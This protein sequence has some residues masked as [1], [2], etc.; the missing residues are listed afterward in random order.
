M[1]MRSIRWRLAA[2]YVLLTLLIV[3]LVGT[4][5]LWLVRA[6]ME[7][8]EIAFLTANANSVARQVLPLWQA[9]SVNG[10]VTYP[11]LLQLAPGMFILPEVPQ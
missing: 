10:D 6:S 5:T 7:R 8:Q 2:S 9:S 4:A 3:T 11:T 1:V